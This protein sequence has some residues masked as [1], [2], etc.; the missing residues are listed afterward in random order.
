MKND[1]LTYAKSGVC[2]EAQ[3]AAIA[4]FKEA[5]KST[6][7]PE[8]LGGVGG[9]AGAFAPELG[10]YKKPTFVSSTDGVGTK[11]R[12]HA[13]FGTHHWAGADLVGAVVND[14]VVTGA[15][16]LFFLDYLACHAVDPK[17]IDQ[18]VGGMAV[19]CK[20]IG[21]ALIG[22]EI[23]EMG[24]VY[25]EGEYDL[26]G[27][28]VGLVDEH[29][30]LGS[31]KVEVDD[32]IVGVASSGVH[33]NGFSLVRK[34]FEHKPDG[35]WHEEAPELGE[36]WKDALL[37]PT[38]CYANLMA[39][40]C[41]LIGLKAAAHISG[42]GLIDNLPRVVPERLT[43]SIDRNLIE[44]P[45]V[46]KIIQRLGNV[47]AKEM[48]HVFNMG[49]G[50]ALVVSKPGLSELVQTCERLGYGARTIGKITAGKSR[51]EWSS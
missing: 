32:V 41:D 19:A 10:S 5:V 43:A 25:Q 51:F 28:A 12:L 24:D 6:Y 40:V 21:C 31:H 9:F 23:A 20:E 49:T 4:S 11:V 34:L 35:F 33:C 1:Q 45:L 15:K 13:R 18:A 14:V 44:V 47:D 36:S 17:V 38:L 29:K 3:D 30:M 50:F 2:I 8:V 7:G 26:A 42:G 22:G 37:K 48:W 16:P 39:E 46:F 27:F